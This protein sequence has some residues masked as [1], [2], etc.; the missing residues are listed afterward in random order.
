MVEPLYRSPS[1]DGVLP[2]MAFLQVFTRWECRTELLCAPFLST[3]V[4]GSVIKLI[5][6]RCFGLVSRGALSCRAEP[7]LCGGG[8]RPRASSW[9]TDPGHVR[10][11]RRE[12]LP[13][14]CTHEGS[15]TRSRCFPLQGSEVIVGASTWEQEQWVPKYGP[16]PPPPNASQHTSQGWSINVI[17]DDQKHIYFRNVSPDSSP[18]IKYGIIFRPL[19]VHFETI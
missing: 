15:G 12:D 18:I 3:N 10:R 13:H 6:S 1:F 17:F 7:S 16:G 8:P 11:T 14:R 19:K 2:N 5:T 4:P 9:R